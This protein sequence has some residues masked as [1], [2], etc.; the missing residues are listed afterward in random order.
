MEDETKIFISIAPR[1]DV[2]VTRFNGICKFR[3]ITERAEKEFADIKCAKFGK[4][5][6][7]QEQMFRYMFDTLVMHKHLCVAE[8][9]TKHQNQN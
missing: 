8:E 5:L 7:V 9:V 4:T 2:V 6:L 1:V 3:P